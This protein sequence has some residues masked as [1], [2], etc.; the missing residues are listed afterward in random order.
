MN[1]RARVALSAAGR[2]T[3][4]IERTVPAKMR[5][6][7]ATLVAARGRRSERTSE[8]VPRTARWVANDPGLQIA[9]SWATYSERVGS[10]AAETEGRR[11]G[12][13][14]M[15]AAAPVR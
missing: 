4:E 14:R 1:Q 5:F 9:S 8:R 11:S 6:A 10:A 15:T 13:S 3:W 7:L 2:G 12:T